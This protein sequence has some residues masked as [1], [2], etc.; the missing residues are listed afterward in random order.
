MR[1]ASTMVPM[2]ALGVL[3]FQA[4]HALPSSQSILPH[5]LI[6][7]FRN[8]WMEENTFGMKSEDD[9][10]FGECPRWC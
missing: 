4:I 6:A 1:K 8:S 3:V 10:R 7:V 2:I 9:L 5:A